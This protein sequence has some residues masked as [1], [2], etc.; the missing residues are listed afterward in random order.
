MGETEK[1]E[2]TSRKKGFLM[3]QSKPIRNSQK[4]KQHAMGLLE[5]SSGPLYIEYSFL[6]ILLMK[7]LHLQR[8]ESL[9]LQPFLRDFFKILFWLGLFNFELTVYFILMYFILLCFVVIF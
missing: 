5:S 4:L 7:L 3:Q 1:T 6:F 9:I 2:N 8:V